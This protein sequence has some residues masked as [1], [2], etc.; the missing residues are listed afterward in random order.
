MRI[1]GNPIQQVLGTYLKQTRK[2]D[3]AAE[4]AGNKTDQVSVSERAAELLKARNALNQVPDVRADRV[5]AVREKLS[6]GYRPDSMA[7][8]EA[9]LKSSAGGGHVSSE[10]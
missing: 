7:V 6:N 8:S 9:I 5:A 10:E 3:P 2:T 4:N 1:V